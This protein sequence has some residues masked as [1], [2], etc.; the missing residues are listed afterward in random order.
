MR[1]RFILAV[2]LQFAV[3]IG[4]LAYRAHW[5]ATGQRVVLRTA[6]V[7]PRD[8][9]RGEYLELSGKWLKLVVL[10]LRFIRRKCL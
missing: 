6:P 5:V 2:S 10:A 3:L 1:K 4:I 8:I 7:D 9:F